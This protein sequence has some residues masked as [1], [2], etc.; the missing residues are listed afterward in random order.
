MTGIELSV[1]GITHRYAS[2]SYV[3]TLAT[4]SEPATCP[5]HVSSGP[6][7]ATAGEVFDLAR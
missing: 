3:A 4:K 2:K 1:E 5:C 7:P 6:R